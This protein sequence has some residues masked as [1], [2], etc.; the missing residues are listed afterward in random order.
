MSPS[1]PP[2]PADPRLTVPP[3]I[4]ANN[5]PRPPTATRRPTRLKAHGDVRVDD[6]HW[7]RDR[8]DPAVIAYL[9]A[10]NGYTDAMTAASA[11]LRER[12]YEQIKARIQEDDLSAPARH[13]RWWYWSRTAAGSQYRV[14]CR[15]ADPERTLD[16]STALAAAATGAGE[17]ILDVNVLA[18]GHEFLHVGVFALS[19]DQQL[20]AYGVDHDGSERYALRFRDLASGTDLADAVDDVSSTAAWAADGETLF[21]TRQDAAMRPHEVWRHRLGRPAEEDDRLFHEPDE[22]FFVSVG[23]TR[24]Q[25]FVLI[26]IDSKQTSE[27]RFIP[28]SDPIAEPVTIA[29]RSQG[30]E[31][32][33]DHAVL[34]GGDAWLVRGNGPA[35]DGSP[36]PNFAV[37]LVPID[38][39]TPRTLVRHRDDA[40]IT[41]VEAFAGH[42]VV[43][44]RAE[45]LER[46]R[47]VTLPTGDQHV[48]PQPEPVYATGGGLN[49]EFDAGLFR[50]TYASLVSPPSTVDYELATRRRTV[51]KTESV[52]GGYDPS[53]YRSERLWAT[54]PDGTRVP[55]SLVARSDIALDGDAPCLLYG[56]G[57][58]EIPID[59][60]FSAARLN[61][62][63]RGFVFAIAHVRGGGELGRTWY[64]QGRLEHKRNTFTDFIACAE[65]LIATGWTGPDRLVIRGGSAGGLLMGAVT[66]L[67][68]DL[69]TAVVAEVPFVDVLTTMSDETLPLTVTEWEEWG[70]PVHDATAYET[71][72]SY[73]PYDNVAPVAYPSIYVTAGLNDPRVGFWEPAKWVAKLR[74]T[75][76]DNTPA[77]L[78]KTELGAGHQG[79]SGRYEEWRDEAR[80]Q[81]F[82]LG[83]VG[84]EN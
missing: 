25:R 37:Q 61:L 10:E 20:L 26:A 8:D 70:D 58:Y 62:L 68:P 84:I 29:P 65:H 33:A 22:R 60:V 47:I 43:Y 64:E 16:A 18:Q 12:L 7:L 56:Y 14:H 42:A 55:I 5:S 82:V 69:W 74:M 9:E 83:A 11:G 80:V 6:W 67:R 57:A 19:H 27:V 52:L 41:D 48:V 32:Q 75:R 66:N 45:A 23:L 76:A 44:E 30:I 17:V 49:A 31:Y 34:P 78:L 28:A 81:A 72:R 2:P 24:S 39:G 3:N 77:L 35:P 51:V 50:F 63:E 21:Y 4:A 79:P 38:G 53:M 36:C 13:G 15:L 40:T 59:P 73:S 54:A 71:I 1:T 46:I